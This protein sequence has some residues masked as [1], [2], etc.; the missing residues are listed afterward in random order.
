M[1]PWFADLLIS[2]FAYAKQGASDGSG[3][4]QTLATAAPQATR[5]AFETADAQISMLAD[6]PQAVQTASLESSLREAD[7]DP[8]EYQNLMEAW[9][10][11]DDHTLYQRDVLKLKRETPALY[12]RLIEDRNAAWTNV[13]A[14][15]LKG[16]GHV[17]VVVGAGHLV[18]PG[19]A[20]ARLRALGFTVEGPAE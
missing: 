2:S 15:R 8:K 19:G 18:G 10:K 6:A 9:L 20:P 13:L 12:T 7:Q 1:Q 5:R 3:V 11:G 4:E 14:D 16:H 17:V